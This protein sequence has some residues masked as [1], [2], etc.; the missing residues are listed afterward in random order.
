MDQATSPVAPVNSGKS[1]TKSEKRSGNTLYQELSFH[2][3]TDT[4]MVEGD[5]GADI[6]GKY[7]C[8]CLSIYEKWSV[9]F[10][11]LLPTLKLILRRT[12][13]ITFD[14]SMPIKCSIYWQATMDKKMQYFMGAVFSL[15]H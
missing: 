12:I 4:S 7:T 6:T 2:D 15:T 9:C 5:E 10:L 11:S 3:A 1:Q 8:L 13:Y 14:V